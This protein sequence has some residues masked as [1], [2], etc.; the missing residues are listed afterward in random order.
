M[1][2][3]PFD[4]KSSYGGGLCVPGRFVH[5]RCFPTRCRRPSVGRDSHAS[6]D[7]RHRGTVPGGKLAAPGNCCPDPGSLRATP[8]HRATI[9]PLIWLTG[10]PNLTS[11]S[12]GTL[13][14]DKV[15]TSTSKARR[16]SHE[17]C[18]VP[19]NA[20]SRPHSPHSSGCPGGS[21]SVC[22]F[23]LC[24]LLG[25]LRIYLESYTLIFI[26]LFIFVFLPFLG[27]LPA[28]HGGSQAKGRIG[29]VAAWP[30]PEPQQRRIRATSA[31]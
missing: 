30:R 16:C 4:E 12:Q 19:P 10:G 25:P 9:L 28:A 23:H 22:L 26:Y 27:P 5:Q 8:T 14:E 18:R 29:A 31:T 24:H 2:P 3:R 13:L 11:Y 6:A 15:A 21:P 20:V 7:T 17:G 1:A